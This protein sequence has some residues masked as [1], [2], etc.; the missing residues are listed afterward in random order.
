MLA[1]EIALLRYSIFFWLGREE[2]MPKE[3][4]FTT[5]K[6]SGYSA[7]M[8]ILIL[9]G[10]IELVGAHILITTFWN[11]TAA[12]VFSVL[13]AY[14]LLFLVADYSA[15]KKRPIALGKDY[16]RLRVGLRW[17]SE[18]PYSRIESVEIRTKQT[19][20]SAEKNM[21]KCVS[22]GEGTILLTLTENINLLGVYGMKKSA[23]ILICSIDSPQEFVATLLDKLH[24]NIQ[25]QS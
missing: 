25:E 5:Y 13:S 1:S 16:M 7:F 12:L 4:V 6:Q 2:I 14:T 20:K 17:N 21:V 9:I 22:F 24:K 15:I 11:G 18:I 23:S 19:N 3:Q 10:F 8:P